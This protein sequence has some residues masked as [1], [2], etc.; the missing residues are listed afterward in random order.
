MD[1]ENLKCPV[2]EEKFKKGDDIVV[3]PE[4]GTPHHRQCYES[5]GKCFFEDK[6][7]DDFSYSEDYCQTEENET[8]TETHNDD[9]VECPRC[10]AKNPK[11]S[12]Y[13]G[14]C[15]FPLG[16]NTNQ[17]NQQQ[18]AANFYNPLDPMAGVNPEYKL[19]DDVTAGEASKFAQKSTQYFSRV[20][21]NIK[22]FGRGRFNFCAFLFSGGY[23]LY[24]KMYKIGTV[25]TVI[26]GLLLVASA[27]FN[28]AYNVSYDFVTEYSKIAES[29]TAYSYNDMLMFYQQAF[30]KLDTIQQVLL[31]LDIICSVVN[32]ALKIIIGVKANRWYFNHTIKEISKIKKSG[33]VSVQEAIETKGGVNFALALSLMI[34]YIVIS[35]LP[36]F[37]A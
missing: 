34:A 25:L 19:S 23:L 27:Y 29:T 1:Y 15:G 3:C 16:I 11:D 20:F 12:F 8:E 26:M 31:I 4:C 36:G 30:F 13:C 14:K 32:F 28:I 35:Y 10:K 2:C 37:I 17:N 7:S 18:Q 21:Y 9:A 24:R 22:E 5:M 6:H 33:T